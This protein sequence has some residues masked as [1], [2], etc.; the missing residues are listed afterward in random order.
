MRIS[1]LIS[2][3]ICVGASAYL[4]G[5]GLYVESGVV[6][7]LGAYNSRRVFEEPKPPFESW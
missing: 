7:L 5:L 4:A 1:S 3:V 6:F 2:C